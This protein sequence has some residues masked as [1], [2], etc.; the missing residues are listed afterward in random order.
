M[1]HPAPRPL[2]RPQKGRSL[3]LNQRGADEAALCHV[4]SSWAKV[5]RR[6]PQREALGV[7]GHRSGGLRIHVDDHEGLIEG[8]HETEG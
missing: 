2:T 1:R 3:I 5:K 4:G 6:V 7:V 8:E